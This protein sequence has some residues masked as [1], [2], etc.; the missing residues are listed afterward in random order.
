MLEFLRGKTSERKLRLF[1]VQCFRQVWHLLHDERSHEA[2]R[3]S[4]RY[5]DGAATE[6][7]LATASWR[8]EAAVF[9]LDTKADDSRYRL[10]QRLIRS[11]WL[12]DDEATRNAPISLVDARLGAQTAELVVEGGVPFLDRADRSILS[13]QILRDIFGNPF[14]PV[15]F[16]PDWL[17]STV[18]ALSR[19]IYEDR[20]FDR[21]PILADALEDAG[22]ENEDV[23]VHCGSDGPHVR[24]CWVVD[25]VL[26]KE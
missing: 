13:L 14:R 6:E 2:V 23:I 25:L 3:V 15:L 5:A 12:T 8:A 26:G 22:C 10:E 11:G 7:E 1:G 24:G 17:T 19:G 21:L 20:A 9:A 4:E 16:N 18:I